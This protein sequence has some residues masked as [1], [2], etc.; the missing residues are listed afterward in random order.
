MTRPHEG[1]ERWPSVLEL[2]FPSF[3]FPLVRSKAVSPFQSRRP[4]Q[5]SSVSAVVVSTAVRIP[6]RYFDG[7]GAGFPA[8]A[9]AERAS[10][11][12]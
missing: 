4:F 10:I 11:I 7:G 1:S 3:R 2:R 8:C 5:P 6:P 9:F 12:A